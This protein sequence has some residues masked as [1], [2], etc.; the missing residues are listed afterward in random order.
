MSHTQISSEWVT[1][2]KRKLVL[3]QWD[4]FILK[5]LLTK[6]N[7]DNLELVGGDILL[8]KVLGVCVCVNIF[9]VFV[10]Q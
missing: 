7:I 10:F 5:D 3:C 9:I 6:L 1:Y 8:L 2:L 4:I